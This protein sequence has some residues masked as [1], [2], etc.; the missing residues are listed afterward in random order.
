MEYRARESEVKF[1]K[2][3]FCGYAAVYYDPSIPGSESEIEPGKW[4]RLVRG[5]FDASLASGED[6]L[7]LF[8][9]KFDTVLGSRETKTS[10][11][12]SDNIGL[13]YETP[14]VADDT[15]HRMARSKIERRLARGA[16]VIMEVVKDRFTRE[17]GKLVRWIERA[18]L[19]EAGPVLWPY[20]EATTA[21]VRS[22]VG[23][24]ELI[25]D[26]SNSE[27]K[28]AFA[29]YEATQKWIKRAEEL[30]TNTI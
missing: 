6:I 26:F 20:Y 8:N 24:N 12:R 30:K 27:A 3:K 18:I 16:S 5:C 21:A 9:H 13:W 29:D 28:K 14:Y 17:G 23:D 10:E 2:E 1:D 25:I 19:R 4:E 7:C 15:D 22:K 11:F